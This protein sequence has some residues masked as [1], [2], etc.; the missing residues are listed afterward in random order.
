[1]SEFRVFRELGEARGVFGPSAVAIGNFDG[2]H[3]GHQAVF[4]RCVEAARRHGCKP[5]AMTFDPHPPRVLTPDRAPRLLST[6][7]QRCAWI[8]ECGIVQVLI[9]PFTREFS[10]LSPEEF[11]RDVLVGCAGVRAVFVGENFHFGHRKAGSVVS[12]SEIRSLIERGN[13]SLAARLLGRAYGLE[14]GVVAG[15]GIGSRETVPTLN[16]TTPAEVLPA[17]GV[18]VTRTL[19]LDS[20]QCWNSVSNVGV[21]PT[22]GAEDHITVE[23]FLLESPVQRPA[24]IRVD[25]LKRLREERKFPDAATLRAQ[26]L[27]DVA[28]AQAFHRRTARWRQ[29]DAFTSERAVRY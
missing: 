28:R 5:S 21:R 27:R 10:M 2:V 8:G 19:D 15:R 20:G 25:F 23:S 22:F 26:I 4:D 12:S 16:L 29:D 9:V 17:R 1:V 13:V 6:V 24:C 14:G 18:Y 7:E 11:V 3:R